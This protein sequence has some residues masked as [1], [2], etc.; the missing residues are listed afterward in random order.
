MHNKPELPISRSQCCIYHHIPAS[1]KIC[2][3]KWH[4]KAH[5]LGI[6]NKNHI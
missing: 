2:A 4:I 6:L 5:N 3:L 1:T